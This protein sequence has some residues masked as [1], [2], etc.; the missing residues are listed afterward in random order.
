MLEYTVKVDTDGT[1]H[2]YLKGKLHCEDGPA[3]EWTDGTKHWYQKGKLH[4]EDGPAVEWAEGTKCWHLSGKFHREDGPAIEASDGNKWW[5]LNGKL[6]TEE[7]HKK[8]TSKPTC[9]GKEVT[10]DGITYVLKMKKDEHT[11]RTK[12]ITLVTAADVIEAQRDRIE[13]LEDVL[14]GTSK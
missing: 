14:K 2:W 12:L 8:A 5:Y 3:I 11:R 4:R 1:K 6:L 13:E 7:D 9:S 10:I